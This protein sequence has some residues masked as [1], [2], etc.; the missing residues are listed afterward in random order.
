MEKIFHLASVLQ[1]IAENSF[2]SSNLTL[3]GGTAINLFWRE[4]PRLS[5]DIDFDFTGEFQKQLM[6]NVKEPI[7]DAIKKVGTDLGYVIREAPPSYI[8]RRIYFRYTPLRLPNDSLK[9]EIN[10]LNR[11]PLLPIVAKPFFNI[12]PDKISDFSVF[13]FRS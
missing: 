3:K 4:I 5:I 10:F 9:I 11:V 13:S 6:L 1:K 7:I 2:L 8:I 12:F